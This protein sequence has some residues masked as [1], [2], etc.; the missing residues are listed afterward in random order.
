M[1]QLKDF[2][3]Q[4]LTILSTVHNNEIIHRDVKP[5]NILKRK[6]DGMYF[7]IDFGIAAQLVTGQVYAQTPIG[8]VGFFAPELIL[9]RT[10]YSSDI[11]GLG[12]T[13]C[14]LVVTPGLAVN[15]VRISRPFLSVRLCA[16]NLFSILPGFCRSGCAR[17]CWQT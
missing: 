13:A 2:L 10:A 6:S 17:V 3:V 4:L 9:G 16:G 8:T 7:L 5:Q 15:S 1:M 14:L 11:F 12:I